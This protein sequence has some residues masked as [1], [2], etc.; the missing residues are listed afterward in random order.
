MVLRPYSLRS[1]L[2][3]H[4]VPSIRATPSHP[5]RVSTFPNQSSA[6]R[7]FKRMSTITYPEARRQD[8]VEDL[9]GVN[10]ADPYRWLEDP[11]SEETKVHP[12]L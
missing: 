4:F 9:H 1:A 12:E 2:P 7:K 5:Q 6:S 3:K 11:K 10:V 8:L